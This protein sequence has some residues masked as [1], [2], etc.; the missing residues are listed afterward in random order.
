[1]V[2][3][4]LQRAGAK[5][6]PFYKI[7]AIDERNARDSRAL[8]FLGTYDPKCDPAAVKL[9]LAGV[10]R[11]VGQGAQLSETVASLVQRIRRAGAAAP[12]TEA[13]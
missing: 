7:V 11:W 8:E 1:M 12:A 4:R 13:S 5:K 10:D 9:D 3:I 2:K 6:R